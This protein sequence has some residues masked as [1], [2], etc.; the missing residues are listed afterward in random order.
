[1]AAVPTEHGFAVVAVDGFPEGDAPV[2]FAA[3][4]CLRQGLELEI[5]HVMPGHLPIGP[6]W[7]ISD[8]PELG[9]FASE[10]LAGAQRLAAEVAPQLAIS[11]HTLTGGRVSEIVA[12]AEHARFVVLGRRAASALDRAWAG[13][14]LDGVAS[15]AACPVFIVPQLPEDEGPRAPRV[16]AGFKSGAHAAELFD[17]GF[18]A[19][20]DLGADLDVVHAWRLAGCYDDMV[21]GRVSEP[22]T[23]REQKAVIRE[24]IR[25][26]QESYPHV[27]VAVRVVHEY[28]VRALNDAARGAD[29]LVLVRP[30]HGAAVH[31]LGRTARGVLRFA[32]CP[33]E[34]VPARAPDELTMSPVAIEEEGEL[35]P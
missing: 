27:R 6:F 21:A 5:G 30:L 32:R 23:N 18:R 1:M 10:T 16:V 8:E 14:T 28:P 13:G 34:V 25:P 29:L 12:L 9:A 20:D 22:T 15:R 19:A 33:V 4:E 3:R 2:A 7:M 24:L 17:A 26:W 31:H 11:T 35:V